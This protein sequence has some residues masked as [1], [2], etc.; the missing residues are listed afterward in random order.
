MRRAVIAIALTV[1]LHAHAQCVTSYYPNN[2]AT[3]IG[4]LQGFGVDGSQISAAIGMWGTCTGFGSGFPSLVYNGNGSFNI[5]IEFVPGRNPDANGGCGL[6]DHQLNSSNQVIGGTIF[7]YELNGSTGA[8][9]GSTRVDTIA[10]EL[11]HVLGLGNSACPGY[12]MYG[13]NGISGSRS[14]QTEECNWVNYAWQGPS[15]LGG[16]GPD[17]GGDINNCQSPLLLDLD[18][19]GIR[20]TGLEDPVWFDR[21]GD[22]VPELGGWTN[23]AT[24]EGFLWID[25][26]TNH[27]V[28]GGHE[29]LGVGTR[30]PDG[31]RAP[32]G[33][34]A[35]RV[36][37]RPSSGGNG[38]G[39][40]TAADAIWGRLRVWID[41]NHDGV[42]QPV[43]TGPIHAYGVVTIRL[44]Y[45]IYET[46]EE[47]GNVRLFRSTFKRREGKELNDAAIEDVFFVVQQ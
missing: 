38:D 47:N 22:G 34:E 5:S 26:D 25:L 8:D 21:D 41:S 18:G 9:C 4:V 19:D 32:N 45:T 7:V 29:L 33:F 39:A 10:H 37:D 11:G 36:Y 20:T 13:N 40:I 35:L 12:I 46:P 42:S 23:S 30:L 24:D 44:V 6:F 31:T 28:D 3:S 16:G 15:D 27:R 2:S 14:V 1:T 17:G 43:E